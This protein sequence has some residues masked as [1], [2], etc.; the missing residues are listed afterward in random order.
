MYARRVLA[1]QRGKVDESFKVHSEEDSHISCS[2]RVMV[3]PLL[4]QRR[5]YRFKS[6]MECNQKE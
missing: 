6:G 5:D 3:I 1:P 2:I 4:S